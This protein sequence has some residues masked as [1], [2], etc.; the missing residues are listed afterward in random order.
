MEAIMSF[1]SVFYT[2]LARRYENLFTRR[3]RLENEA[4][5]SECIIT[6]LPQRNRYRIAG[7]IFPTAPILPRYQY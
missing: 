1:I 5:L 4:L 3:F 7:S 6:D 2:I